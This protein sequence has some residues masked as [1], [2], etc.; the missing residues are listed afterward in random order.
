MNTPKRGMEKKKLATKK[1]ILG[2]QQLGKKKFLSLAMFHQREK[3]VMHIGNIK[4]F[5]IKKIKNISLDIQSIL[6]M[7]WC[8]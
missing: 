6:N 8:E 2:K 3:I 5:N 7:H 1:V 4:T